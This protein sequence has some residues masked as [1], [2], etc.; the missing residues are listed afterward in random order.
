MQP[1]PGNSQ[2]V[3]WPQKVR[4]EPGQLVTFKLDSGVRIIGPPGA[5][6]NF[7]FQF[8]NDKKQTVQWGRQT[9]DTQVLPPGTYSLQIRRQFGEWKTVAEHVQV[10]EGV[11]VDVHIP[12]LSR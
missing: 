11:I 12:D 4:V 10:R 2:R 9:W 5:S 6:P 7:E 1:D 8:L 3:V